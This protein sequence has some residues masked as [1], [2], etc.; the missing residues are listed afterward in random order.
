MELDM[1]RGTEVLLQKVV[2]WA[3]TGWLDK[4]VDVVQESKK[5]FPRSELLLYS[6]QG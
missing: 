3:D 6:L 1:G 4:C 2:D 5:M